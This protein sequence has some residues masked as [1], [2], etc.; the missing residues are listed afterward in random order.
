MLLA[1]NANEII[2]DVGETR[3]RVEHKSKTI[4]CACRIFALSQPQSCEVTSKN[5]NS[6]GPL[7]NQ[8]WQTQ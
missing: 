5:A 7:D 3:F 6:G 1:E 8:T 4:I 2:S